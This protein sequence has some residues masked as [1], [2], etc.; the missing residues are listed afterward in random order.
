MLTLNLNVN[1]EVNTSREQPACEWQ[2][3]IGNNA[4]LF[5]CDC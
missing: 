3:A 2:V 5:A 4:F 1:V